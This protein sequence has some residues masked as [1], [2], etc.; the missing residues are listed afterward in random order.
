MQTGSTTVLVVTVITFFFTSQLSST[1]LPIYL[2]DSGMSVPD[3]C[4]HLV[5]FMFSLGIRYHPEAREF[6]IPRSPMFAVFLL[7]F[8]LFGMSES[9]WIAYLSSFTACRL[10]SWIWG[11]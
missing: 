6:S 2:K 8:V 7:S 11:S 5:A 1:F 3:A 9:Y 4:I 10:L